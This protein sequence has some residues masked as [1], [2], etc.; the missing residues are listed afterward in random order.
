MDRS[1]AD[2]RQS[3]GPGSKPC[4][5]E[6]HHAAIRLLWELAPTVS[7]RREVQRPKA[8]PGP[9]LVLSSQHWGDLRMSNWKKKSGEP[10]KSHLS[11]SVTRARTLRGIS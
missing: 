9:G 5:K 3:K 10:G 4:A 11:P 1:S 7:Q 2:F 6:L 8:D